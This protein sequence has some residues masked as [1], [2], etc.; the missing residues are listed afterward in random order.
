LEHL[1]A[2]SQAP[3]RTILFRDREG[4]FA[5]PFDNT[6]Q[7]AG[8]RVH[9]TPVKAPNTNAFVERWGQSLRVE[10]LD[11]ILALGKT[12]F[13]YLVREYVAHYNEERPLQ[14]LGNRPIPE[15]AVPETDVLPFPA[16]DIECRSRF[17][18]LLKSYRRAS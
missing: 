3:D 16:A 1:A 11:R 6:L 13:N 10:C 4:K 17:G 8:I 12:H 18:G 5:P 15:V 2:T 9:R 7:A 14:S